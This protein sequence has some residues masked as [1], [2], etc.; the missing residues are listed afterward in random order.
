MISKG[1]KRTVRIIWIII[2]F[3][4]IFAMIVFTLLPAFS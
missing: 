3:I 4:G 2:T 1:Q